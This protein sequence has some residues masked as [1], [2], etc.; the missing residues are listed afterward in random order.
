MVKINEEKKIV[1]IEKYDKEYKDG[2]SKRVYINKRS[3]SN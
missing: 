2:K 3:P 1:L